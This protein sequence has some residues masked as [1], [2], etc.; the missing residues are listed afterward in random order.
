MLTVSDWR[1]GGG[2]KPCGR[3]VMAFEGVMHRTFNSE[4]HEADDISSEA[5][6]AACIMS[7]SS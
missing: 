6:S 3:L 2:G 7:L 4:V 1:E 5:Q